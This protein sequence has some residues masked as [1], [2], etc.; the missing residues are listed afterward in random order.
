MNQRIALYRSYMVWL[1]THWAFDPCPH[2]YL[3]NKHPITSNGI[4]WNDIP[5]NNVKLLRRDQIASYQICSN[6][7]LVDVWLT[8][9]YGASCYGCSIQPRFACP[10]AHLPKALTHKHRGYMSM[11]TLFWSPCLNPLFYTKS[12]WEKCELA[13]FW[14]WLIGTMKF[15]P[16]FE[17]SK[18]RS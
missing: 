17:S 4:S 15:T 9:V 7:F 18:K 13:R 11:A 6:W 8:S 12:T 2:W 3:Q 1:S 14:I 16:C 10:F 5:C